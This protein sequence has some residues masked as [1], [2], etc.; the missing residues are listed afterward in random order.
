MDEDVDSREGLK[1]QR[2][3]RRKHAEHVARAGMGEGSAC[4]PNKARVSALSSISCGVPVMESV[5]V[6]LADGVADG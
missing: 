2:P 6:V 1:S 4:H 5:R 3:K